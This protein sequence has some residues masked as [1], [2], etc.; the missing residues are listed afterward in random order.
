VAGGGKGGGGSS[1]GDVTID[2][3]S[4]STSAI[5]SFSTTNL[6]SKSDS[7]NR[8]DSKSD[9]D[10]RIVG[11]DNIRLKADS[12]ADNKTQLEM[13]LK[14]LQLDLCLKVGLERFPPTRICKPSSKRFGLTVFGVEVFGFTYDGDD[15]TIIE[16]L[17]KRP[18][19]VADGL[20]VSNHRAHHPDG[21]HGIR[22]RLA[23]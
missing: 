4:T 7:H 14:P 1:G 23:D 17:G 22:I 5:D 8:I 15:T 11:L 19:V 9:A 12:T 20:G 2:S 6:D 13:D 16:D 10:F 21:N 18:F 3:T